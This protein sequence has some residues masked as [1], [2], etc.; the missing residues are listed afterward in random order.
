MTLQLP[1]VDPVSGCIYLDDASPCGP[2]YYGYPIKGNLIPGFP[3]NYS[4]LANYISLFGSTDKSAVDIASAFKCQVSQI[5]D[6]VAGLRYQTSFL[7]SNLVLWSLLPTSGPAYPNAPFNGGGCPLPSIVGSALKANGPLICKEQCDIVA[8]GIQNIIG[9]AS[10]CTDTAA[11][12]L[13]L[14]KD[15]QACDAY[16]G[17]TSESGGCLA[18]IAKELNLCGE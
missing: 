18:G 6:Q 8:S 5:A 2:E 9:D 12:S 10:I 4:E 15:R 3:A 16:V 11:V 17:F 14:V 7:C 13:K 1:Y